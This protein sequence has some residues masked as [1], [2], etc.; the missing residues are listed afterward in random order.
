L[1]VVV[2]DQLVVKIDQLAG[3]KANLLVHSLFMLL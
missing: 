3:P 2:V 1:E